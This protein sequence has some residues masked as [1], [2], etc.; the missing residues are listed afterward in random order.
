MSRISAP[1]ILNSLMRYG[2]VLDLYHDFLG[3]TAR[4]FG[5]LRAACLLARTWHASGEIGESTWRLRRALVG[6]GFNSVLW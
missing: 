5:A 4:A 2:S 6:R 1:L 3:L